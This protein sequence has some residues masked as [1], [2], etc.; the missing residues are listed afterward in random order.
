MHAIIAV[1]IYLA[2]DV[3]LFFFIFSLGMGKCEY[4]KGKIV[5]NS[6]KQIAYATLYRKLFA[7]ESIADVIEYPLAVA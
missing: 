3:Y 4:K 2:E 6:V 5:E 7:L 1:I